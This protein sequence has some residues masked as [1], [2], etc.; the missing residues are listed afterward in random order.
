MKLLRLSILLVLWFTVFSA[1]GYAQSATGQI[2]LET[3]LET[4]KNTTTTALNTAYNQLEQTYVTNNNA[5]TLT[6]LQALSCLDIV[7][8]P[9]YQEYLSERK[10]ELR[11]EILE[12][13]IQY[14]MQLERKDNWLSV[15]ESTLTSGIESFATIYNARIEQFKNNADQRIQTVEQEVQAYGQQ[16]DALLRDV[17]QKIQ[18]LNQI[19]ARQEALQKQVFEFNN[20]YLRHEANLLDII[21]TQ[22]N[23]LQSTLREQIQSSIQRDQQR[24]GSFLGYAQA[25]QAKQD[26]QTRL[27]SLDFDEAVQWIVGDRYNPSVYQRLQDQLATV[28]ETFYRDGKLDCQMLLTTS[29]DVDWYL[30]SISSSIQDLELWLEQ[31]V[32]ALS[33]TWA[34]D[35]FKWSVFTALQQFYTNRTQELLNEFTTFKNEQFTLRSSRIVNQRTKVQELQ[36]MRSRYTQA[37]WTEKESLRAQLISQAQSLRQEASAQDIKTN[38]ESLLRGLWVVLEPQIDEDDDQ[39]LLESTNPFVSSL[40]QLA[41]KLQRTNQ[42]FAQVLWNAIPNLESKL[43]NGSETKKTQ[44][45]TLI[46]AVEL[47]VQAYE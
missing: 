33:K 30:Q 41:K 12:E 15:N 28:N 37:L 17:S 20:L 2:T 34:A 38:L 42:E 29:L 21:N 26:A 22:K 4:A 19:Q 9:W 24:F 5:S 46:Q 27:F 31:W 10:N 1:T 40:H 39:E 23:T 32:Q 7:D 13:Y 36:E 18:Q 8:F 11:N 44:I 47:Y 6:H 35:A 16:N 14:K 45:Q 3:K 43:E 25:L